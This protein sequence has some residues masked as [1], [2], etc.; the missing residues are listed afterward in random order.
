MEKRRA[1]LFSMEKRQSLQK[2]SLFPAAGKT[3]Q[4]HVKE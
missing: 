1:L 2:D 4:L 3:E